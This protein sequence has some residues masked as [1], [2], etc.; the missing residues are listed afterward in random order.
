MTFQDDELSYALGKQ[1]GTRSG[2]L[3]PPFHK[4]HLSKTTK[5]F[6]MENHGN[7]PEIAKEETRES[8]W[9]GGPVCWPGTGIRPVRLPVEI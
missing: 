1:G 7:I 8:L 4:L 2:S 5:T 9:C 3:V 6:S